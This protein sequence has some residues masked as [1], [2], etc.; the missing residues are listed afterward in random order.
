MLYETIKLIK[1]TG[2]ITHTFTTIVMYCESR[3][4]KN[5]KLLHLFADTRS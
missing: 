1:K 4:K 2:G 5:E 3:R